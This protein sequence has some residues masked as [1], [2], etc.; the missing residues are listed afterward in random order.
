IYGGE[1]RREATVKYL[2]YA[3][4]GSFF[5]LVSMLALKTLSGAASFHIIDLMLVTPN[6]PVATQTWLFIGLAIGMAVKLPIWPLHSW[7]VDLNEQNHP[8]GAADVL[9]SLYKVG[10]FG[11][12]AW[13]LPLLPAGA[14]RVA[15]VLLALSAV[16]AIYGALGAVGT[17]HLKR[18]L[19]YGS[20][21]HMGIIGVG[22]FGMHL[23]GMSGAM[24]FLAA[25]MVSTGGLFLVMG[26]LYHRRRSLD[27]ADYGG[28]AKSAPA[29][30][31]FALFL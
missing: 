1:K 9:G 26:M 29:L 10:A 11:F 3:V 23:A 14:V 28:V 25:Q 18:F 22:V 17:N 31:A 4:T 8:S 16:T 24:Y 2:V 30:A 6:L 5:M 15:P 13:A 20:L 19:A 12:F 7:L 21:S 27:M